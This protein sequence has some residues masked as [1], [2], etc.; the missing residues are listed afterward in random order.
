MCHMDLITGTSCCLPSTHTHWPILSIWCLMRKWGWRV[1]L[2]CLICE[3]KDFIVGPRKHSQLLS[4]NRYT[5]VLFNVHSKSQSSKQS[6]G[7]VPDTNPFISQPYP[8][9][10]TWGQEISEGFEGREK[11]SRM[12]GEQKRG[13]EKVAPEHETEMLLVPDNIIFH[14]EH[15]VA[16]G[17][18]HCIIIK[19]FLMKEQKAKLW[20]FIHLH[21]CK[22]I[23]VFSPDTPPQFSELT[24]HF[25]M[26]I[27]LIYNGY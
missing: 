19:V 11:Q 27:S 4:G 7:T 10:R 16:Q 22:R 13:K 25:F 1:H 15:Q 9:G 2:A 21:T 24:D 3:K 18:V 17:T 5:C 6:S 23:S 26:H 14:G 20:A 12:D 8:H